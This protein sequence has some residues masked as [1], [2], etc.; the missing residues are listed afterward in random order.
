MKYFFLHFEDLD[1]CVRLSRAG[2][3]VLFVPDAVIAHQQGVSSASR[4]IR[5]EIYKAHSML[6][7]LWKH[8]GRQKWLVPLLVPLIVLRIAMYF[9]RLA[10]QRLLRLVKQ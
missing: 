2:W 5:V 4:P 1:Y 7:F 3:Q 6:R 9:L 8:G 10:A